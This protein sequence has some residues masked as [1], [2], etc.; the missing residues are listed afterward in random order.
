MENNNRYNNTEDEIDLVAL[1]R[2]LKKGKKTIIRFTVVFALIG[3]F[4]AVFTAKEYTASTTLVPQTSSSKPGGALGGLAAM[5]GINLGSGGSTESISPHLYPKITQSI[6][7]KKELLN[8]PL[9]F[10]HLEKEVTY[11]EYYLKYQKTNVLSF[12]KQYTIGLPAKFIGLFKSKKEVIVKEVAKDAIYRVSLEETALFKSLGNQLSLDINPKEGYVK[13]AFSMP[14]AL[15]AAQMTKKVKELLQKSITDFKVQ[16]TKEEYIFI[17]E[18][19]KELKK[20]FENKQATL[21]SFRDRNQGLITSRSKSRIESLQSEYNLAATI[22]YELAKQL[23]TQKIK[24]KENT[25]VFTVLEPVSVPVIKSKPKRGL[26]F[27]IWLL[28][29]VITG[30]GFVFGKDW[31]KKLKDK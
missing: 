20:D 6:L 14:E 11:Q 22:Y 4:I 30:M 27:T 31:L 28:L 9:K 29:G 7:F 5:A 24:L 1:F 12:I 19:Y 3:L 2:T 26:I 25:P 8:V 15:P 21:A 16:K 23:E 17:E 10:S 13:I 18:R